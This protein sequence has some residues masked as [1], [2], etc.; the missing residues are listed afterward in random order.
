L[1]GT[2]GTGIART[3]PPYIRQGVV[4]RRVFNPLVLLLK[5]KPALAVRG[6]RSGR[7][8]SVPFDGPFA[9]EG[10]RYLVSPMGETNWVRN[11][12][13]AGKGE[14]RRGRHRE[15]FG[16]VELRG[17]E[18]DTIVTAYAAGL[19]CGCRPICGVFPTPPTAPSSG[20][21]RWSMT[22]P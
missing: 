21:S 12:R 7:L 2:A 22:S 13:A 11:L 5:P 10:R 15:P 19:T 3:A 6:R 8:R 16:A 18:R 1:T 14:L 9:H 4:T 17:A 20:S